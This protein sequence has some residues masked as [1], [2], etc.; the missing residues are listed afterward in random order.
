MDKEKNDQKVIKKFNCDCNKPTF[1]NKPKK[2]CIECMYKD[3]LY[4]VP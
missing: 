2:D 4:I 1:Q 3:L